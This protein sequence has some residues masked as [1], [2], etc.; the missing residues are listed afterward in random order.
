[1]WWR[2]RCGG[3]AKRSDALASG[4]L[5]SGA[6]GSGGSAVPGGGAPLV[7]HSMNVSDP[8]HKAMLSHVV[9]DGGRGGPMALLAPLIDFGE[10]RDA[11][12]VAEGQELP[13]ESPSG[14][15]AFAAPWPSVSL[16]VWAEDGVDEL[17]AD[18]GQVEA[19]WRAVQRSDAFVAL[20]ECRGPGFS[21]LQHRYSG[22]PAH[23]A[24]VLARRKA[25]AKAKN[26]EAGKDGHISSLVPYNTL[27]KN[28][29]GGCVGSGDGTGDGSD[30]GGNGG[31][32]PDGGDTS[33][34]DG[35]RGSQQGP[36]Q[37]K[38]LFVPAPQERGFGRAIPAEMV[39]VSTGGI[40]V[41]NKAP[42]SLA[43]RL[44]RSDLGGRLSLRVHEIKARPA[45]AS[46][47]AFSEVA[48][49]AALFCHGDLLVFLRPN[50]VPLRGW[51]SAMLGVDALLG[52]G[53]RLVGP[54]VLY[55]SGRIFSAGLEYLDTPI[56]NPAETR[57]LA[58]AARASLRPTAAGAGAGDNHSDGDGGDDAAPSIVLPHQRL[59]G[60]H[61][62]DGR[63][64][65][66]ADAGGDSSGGDGGALAALGVARH[67][68][69]VGRATFFELN[70]FS[71]DLTGALEDA[72]LALRLALRLDLAAGHNGQASGQAGEGGG[73]QGDQGSAAFVAA[74]GR[75]V[76]MNPEG[77]P[78]LDSAYASQAFDFRAGVDRERLSDSRAAFVGRWGRRLAARV[79]SRRLTSAR[80]SWVVHCGGSQ[81]Y[82]AATILA[83][84]EPLAATR[85]IVRRYRECEH[86]DTLGGT[87]G[88]FRDAFDRAATRRFSGPAAAPPRAPGRR[89]R[90]G[91]G[92]AAGGGAD[93]PRRAPRLWQRVV[94]VVVVVGILHGG[95][96]R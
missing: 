31:D 62:R 28:K 86:T 47:L 84:L 61:A 33:N 64:G 49:W 60:Y 71:P 93:P 53:S 91:A 10:R 34:G 69:M 76:A 73:L 95:R 23:K 30:G 24:R 21:A 67:C 38:R 75:V 36:R 3:T 59:R 39:V 37:A 78:E 96:G 8:E 72:D 80:L 17:R 41:S 90:Q 7:W 77:Y 82:E 25:K 43:D 27:A 87:P 5:A 46:P 9:D 68:L 52:S 54:V 12:V 65:A 13:L 58:A 20:D 19:L 57:A 45:G 94:V 14:E 85:M 15:D 1:M 81:G 66:A 2:K 55:P 29:A 11:T 16:L 56:M 74:G 48:D 50:V 63:L 51:L 70:G 26:K 92:R 22:E 88:T 32:G 40:K 18:G 4:A 79:A 83:G 6:P 89:G 44:A 35:A 42:E